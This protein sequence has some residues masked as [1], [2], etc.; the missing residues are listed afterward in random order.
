M[1]MKPLESRQTDGDRDGTRT[2]RSWG[3]MTRS[4][5][6]PSLGT[7]PPTTIKQINGSASSFD[8]FPIRDRSREPTDLTIRITLGRH[9]PHTKLS[10]LEIELIILHSRGRSSLQAIPPVGDDTDHIP[11]P[12]VPE[13]QV[14]E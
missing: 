12:S 2:E 3:E 1:P 14:G 9:R 11:E 13:V 6:I 7:I 4:N 8:K 5:S 10:D